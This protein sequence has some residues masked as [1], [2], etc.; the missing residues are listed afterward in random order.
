M[1]VATALEPS[2]QAQAVVC[3]EYLGHDAVAVLT[4]RRLVLA[5]SRTHAPE[6]ET[7]DVG[8]VTDVKG[9]ADG[10]RATLRFT[11][12]STSAVIGQIREVDAAQAFASALR[13]RL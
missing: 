3:G 13:A 5:N 12:G 6:I 2:E 9:W 7:I 10:G 8:A 1:A 11:A 4:D